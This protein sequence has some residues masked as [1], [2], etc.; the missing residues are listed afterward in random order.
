MEVVGTKSSIAFRAFSLA[1]V[2]ARLHALEA[3]NVEALGQNGVLHTWIAAW[4]RQSSLGQKTTH[5]AILTWITMR[6]TTNRNRQHRWPCN[7]LFPHSGSRLRCEC[8]LQ[9][10][11][12]SLFSCVAWIYPPNQGK[13]HITYTAFNIPLSIY[14][15]ENGRFNTGKP[16]TNDCC[17]AP[18]PAGHWR[19]LS[20]G[21]CCFRTPPLWPK[22][23]SVEPLPTEFARL[24][25]AT[26]TPVPK[27]GRHKRTFSAPQMLCWKYFVS[28]MSYWNQRC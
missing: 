21:R 4:T 16:L 10:S 17:N 7:R 19:T 20:R 28:S 9:V 12:L 11:W 24:Q 23:T 18:V 13:R 2:I 8:S 5:E 6:K 3:K 1:R 22:P 14:R 27:T 15:S 26:P 25:R